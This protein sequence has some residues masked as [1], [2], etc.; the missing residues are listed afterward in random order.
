MVDVISGQKLYFGLS[1]PLVSA[2]ENNQEAVCHRLLDLISEEE[3]SEALT[4]AATAA[5]GAHP[6]HQI[7]ATWA[8]GK[9]GDAKSLEEGIP[10]VLAAAVNSVSRER[11]GL[12][13]ENKRLRS[14]VQ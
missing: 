3:L 13:R 4:L 1:K 12:V 11:D 10:E 6:L 9:R 8:V 2:A 5:R 14:G 7:M